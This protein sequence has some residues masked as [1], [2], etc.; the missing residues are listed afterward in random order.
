MG[1]P[2]PDRGVRLDWADMPTRVRGEIERWMGGAVVGAVTQ[3]TGFTPGVAARVTVDDGRRFFVKAAGPEPN[4]ATPKAHRSEIN[5]VTALP[6]AAPVP[7]LLWSHDE[8]QGG[9]V[10]LAFEDVDGRHPRQPWRLDELDRV[11]AAMEELSSQLT[12]SPL[13]AAVIGTAVDDFS[14]GWRRLHEE[15]PSRIDRVDEWSRRHIE[16]LAAIE[17]TVGPAL[18]GDTLLNHDIRADNILLTR[19]RVWFVDWPHAFVGPPWLDAVGFA[20]S[21]T[22]QGGPPPEE[23]ISRHSACRNADHDAITAAV[24]ALAGFFTHRAVQPPPPGLPTVRAF[25]DAQGTI[26]REWVAQRTGLA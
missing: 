2:P 7:R 18:E 6:R 1:L 11:V 9:W 10:V 12:P 21:V 17:D 3:P 5:I 26:A 19:D 13:P 20:P 14:R 23:V 16:A 4:T 22:M 8:G 15:R 24:V 25:Q